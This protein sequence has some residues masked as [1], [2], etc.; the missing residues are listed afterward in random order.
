MTEADERRE[1]P[2]LSEK[3]KLLQAVRRQPDG[4]PWHGPTDIRAGLLAL[5]GGE[6]V[7]D[8]TVSMIAKVINGSAPNPGALL[9]AG[10]AALFDV[11]ADYLLQPVSGRAIEVMLDV[12]E[13]LLRELAEA[14]HAA[15]PEAHDEPAAAEVT[16]DWT[17]WTRGL[18]LGVKRIAEEIAA[19][20][21]IKPGH[22]EILLQLTGSTRASVSIAE[23][24][25]ECQ[26]SSKTASLA[27]DALE[28]KDLLRPC[29]PQLG[30]P[31]NV[32][33]LAPTQRARGIVAKHTQPPPAGRDVLT[34]LSA[35]DVE[36]AT[37]LVLLMAQR[38][39]SAAGSDNRG[40][41]PVT[42]SA[43]GVA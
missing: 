15:P 39:Q 14:E 26:I 16:P 24:I 22:A 5:Q 20:L 10:L 13:T 8:Y 32:R 31:R 30:D 9:I 34:A 33:R 19:E 17:A 28:E 23:M 2:S 18:T 4:S 1:L 6:V 41:P 35:Q 38:A 27:A 3:I 40:Q 42:G 12:H 21:Q 25:A 43:Q 11:P 37:K 36:A 7:V 29:E